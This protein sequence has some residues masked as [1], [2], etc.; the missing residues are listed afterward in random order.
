MTFTLE[1]GEQTDRICDNQRL[2][3]SSQF[4]TCFYHKDRQRYIQYG[5]RCR[6]GWSERERC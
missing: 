2:C 1:N 4:V 5:N 6:I 3:C